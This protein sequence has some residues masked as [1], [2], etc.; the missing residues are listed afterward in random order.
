MNDLDDAELVRR[1]QRGDARAFADYALAASSELDFHAASLAFGNWDS[2][3]LQQAEVEPKYRDMFGLQGALANLYA[4][5]PDT[6]SSRLVFMFSGE[7][8]RQLRANGDSGTDHG[9]GNC[10]LL[11]G[12]PVCGGIYG[13][14]FPTAELARLADPTPDIDGRTHLESVLAPLVDYLAPGAVDAVLPSRATASIE[15]GVDLGRL[16]TA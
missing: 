9:R 8:G 14:L 12:M 4:V 11:V 13:E 16:F 10:V 6:V 5:L 15:A 1:Y 3:D 2:H 7:F